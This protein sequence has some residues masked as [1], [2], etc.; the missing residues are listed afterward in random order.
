[1]SQRLFLYIDILN[2]S[3]I[4][5]KPSKVKAIYRI[6]DELNV[7]RH[8]PAFKCI[9]FSDT[10]IVYSN[11]D[12][13]SD[14]QDN[15]SIMW[16]CEF[17]QDLF[18]NLI[19]RDVHFRAILTKGEFQ[20]DRLNHIDAFFGEALVRTYKYEKDIM[21][22]GLFMDTSLVPY[23][24]IF[25]TTPYDSNYH[26][27]HIMQTLGSVNFELG[28]FPVPGSLL[29]DTDMENLH[30]YDFR[31]LQ[32]VHRHM[33]DIGLHPSVRAKYLG[34]WQMLKMRNPLLFETFERSGLNPRSICDLDWTEPMRRIGTPKGYFG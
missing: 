24:H 14:V 7:F 15:A 1:M 32:N 2:F 18:Y 11:F 21:C 28:Q 10:I 6:I 9:V 19:S 17:A 29:L 3:N 23:S 26:F 31:Y 34:T 22:M 25:K 27:V 12:W 16:M 13:V 4:I 8:E 30:A 33:T 20:H 5:T